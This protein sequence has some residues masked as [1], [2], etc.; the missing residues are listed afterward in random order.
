VAH[1]ADGEDVVRVAS[2]ASVPLPD[3]GVTS[4]SKFAGVCAAPAG[5]CVHGREKRGR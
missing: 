4:W 2:S 3:P 5:G 1:A